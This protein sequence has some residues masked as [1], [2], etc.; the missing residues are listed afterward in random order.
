MSVLGDR[1]VV[2]E[3][4]SAA[5]SEADLVGVVFLPGAAPV[6]DL[7]AVLQGLEQAGL[8]QRLW[9]LTRGAVRVDGA[10]GPGDLEAAAAWGLGRVAAL[11]YP[12]WWGG[13]IDLPPA[14]AEAALD[15]LIWR[16][17]CAVLAGWDA[18]DQVAVRASGVYGRR[19][20]PAPDSGQPWVPAGTVLVTG[21]TGGLGGQVARWLADQ[22]VEHIVLTSR[23]GTQAPG[24]AQ[25][26]DELTAEGRVRVTVLGCDVADRDGLATA[27]SG[28]GRIDAVVHAAGVGE[29]TPIAETGPEAVDQVLA[30][31]VAGTMNLH[32][33]LVQD[34]ERPLDAFVMFSSGAGVWGGG[35]QGTYAAANAFLDAYA[36]RERVAGRAVTSVSWGLWAGPGMAGA[37]ESQAMQRR[38]VRPMDP[39]RALR[40]LAEAVGRGEACVTVTDM[41][42]PRF[43]VAFT[44]ARPSP[45][46]GQIPQVRAAAADTGSARDEDSALAARLRVLPE[47][48]RRQA[49]HEMVLAHAAAV[50][51]HGTADGLG[52]GQAFRELGFDSV[53]A[54][55][56]RNRLVEATGLSLPA[57]LVFDYPNAAVLTDFLLEELFG[58][59]AAMSA[60][61]VAAVLDEPVAIVGVGCRFPG[62]VDSPEALWEL[63][64]EGTD[65]IGAFPGNRGWDAAGLDDPQADYARVGG[66]VP[67]VTD[68]DAGFFGISPREA[69]A[70][71]PQQ[72]LVLQTAW[73]ALERAGIAPDALRGSDTG[74]YVG[75][76]GSEYGSV[77]ASGAHDTEGHSLT[78]NAVSVM[79]G[80]VSYNLG[81]EGPAVSV[82]TACSSSLV[83][84]H[85]AAQALRSGEC[86]M[87][88]AGGVTV[89]S[90]PG[91]F[92]EFSRQG[93]LA[94]DG[95]CKPFADAAD[96]TGWGEGAG[97]LVLERLSDA[98][99]HGHQILAMLRGSA[100]N[101]D[102][103][104]NGLTAPNGPSQQRVIRAALASARLS[105]ADVDVVEAHGTGTKLGDP[106]EAQALLATYGQ[107][108]P[109]DRPLWLGSVKSNIGHTQA[110][111]GVAGI[112]KIVLA[113]RHG[114]LPRTLHVD[115]PSSHV[116]W[117]AG[118]VRLL[119]EAVPWEP[120]GRPRRA[121]VSS[122]GISGTNAHLI[123]EEA[124][125]EPELVSAT[126]PDEVPGGLVPWL[127]SARS[128]DALRDQAVRLVRWS[129]DQ[130]ETDP[131]VVARA[132]A[133]SRSV[134]EHRAVVL[135]RDGQELM[136]GLR[137]LAERRP[138]AG[139][140]TG[141]PGSGRLAMVFSGQG[142]QRLGMGAELYASFPVFA[143]ALDEVCAELDRHLPRPI[144][145]VIN[146]EPD[147]LNETVF[148][149]A[150]LFAVQVAL[151]RL[152]T[153]WGVS[154]EWVAGHSIGELS[155]AHVAGVWSLADAASV[156][157][158]RGR[159]MQE[160]PAGGA[161]AALS[162][163]E[164]EALELIGECATVGLAAV[165]G[166]AS[167]VV[168]GDE[169]VVL[170]LAERWRKQG[171][172]ARRLQVS[173]AFHSLLMEPMLASFAQ[174]L[175]GVS[176]RE[177][178]FPVVSGTQDADVTD[179]AYWVRHVRETVRYHDT[180][181]TLR[182][183]GADLFL[184]AGPDGTLSAMAGVDSGVWVPALRGDRDEPETL[185]TALA[186][187]H[188]HSATVDWTALLGA[189]GSRPVPLPTYAF[190]R[191]R[192]WPAVT[193]R[194][195][196][197][198][199]LG[200]GE[201]GH[202]LLGAVVALAGGDAVV[203][204]GRLSLASY[205]WLADHA[206]LGSVLL[207]GTA[208]VDLAVHAG[209]RAGCPVVEEL[210]LQAPLLL[211]EQGGVQVQVRV[212][213]PDEQGRRAVGILSRV[214]DDD[215]WIRHAEGVLSSQDVPAPVWTGAWP[216]PDAQPLPVDGRYERLAEDGYGYG[217][218]FQGLRAAWQS[219]TEVIAE[220]ALPEQTEVDGFGI[221]PALLDAALHPIGLAALAQPSEGVSLPFAW[222][223]VRL[224]ATG[225]SV[226][227]V[228]LSRREDGGVGIAAFDP[229][230]QPVFS[231]DSLRLRPISAD[232]A[233]G[234]GESARSLFGVDWVPL[235]DPGT[236]TEV[237][238]AWHGQVD[239]DVPA[240]VVAHVPTGYGE[241]PEW[242][243]AVTS[244]VLGW[245]QT[246]LADSA[247]Q[248]SRL[249]LLTRGAL[250]G[251]DLAAAA[252][253]GLVRSAQSEHPG[254]FILLDLDTDLNLDAVLPTVLGSGEPELAV[255][256][257]ALSVRRLV[258]AAGGGQA[259]VA[260]ERLAEGTVVITGGTGGL[261]VLLA[262]HLVAT[263]EVGHL[264]LLSRRGI[265]AP[266]AAELAAELGAR[267][268]IRACDVS[269]RDAA[270]AVL[271][272]V[273]AQF[274][275]AGVVHAAGV[276]DDATVES[277]SP[278]RLAVVLRA[279]VDA[280]WHL[281]E[282]TQ[283][284]D[285]GLFVVY[286][287]AAATLGSAGQG[288][289]AAANAALD[290]LVQQRRSAGLAGHSLAW[291][292]WAQR[293]GMT[294]T[295][296]EA[297]L[298]RMSRAGLQALS[299]EEGLALFD[300]AVRLDRPLVVVAR[301][302]VAAMRASGVD[303]RLLRGLVGGSAR[304][305]AAS[306][307]AHGGELAGRLAAL[308]VEERHSAVLELVRTQ[309]ATV[310][311]HATVGGVDAD[312]A[313]RD[314]GFDSLT[315]V[316]LRNRLAS[317]TD[318]R[319]P[320]TLVFDY[321]TASVLAEFVLAEL[322]GTGTEAT[323][324]ALVAPVVEE[325]IAIVGMGCRFPGGVDSP[326]ALWELL[327]AGGEGVAEFPS[328]RGWDV[329]GLYD[330]EGLRAGTSYTKHGGFLLG[331]AEFDAGF[332]G[333][334]PREAVGMDPQQRI[335]LETAWEALERAGI[336]PDSLRGSATGVYLGLM[337][338][339]YAT[340]T[341]L[342]PA[343]SEGF[344]STGNSGSVASGRI[345]Y[346][347]GLEGPAV[348]VDTACSSS[349]VTVHLAAQALR[350][351]ECSL[352]L[353]GGVTVMATPGVF[354]EFSRQGGLA[355]DG[356]CKPF[357]DAA[358]GTSWGEG[359]GVLVLERLSDARRRGHQ[360]LAVLRGSAV[361]QD[362]ASNGLT[363]PNGPSQQRVIRAAL[364]SARLVASDVDVVEAHGTGTKL[365]DPIEAQALLAT[366]GQDRPEGRPLWL[367]SVKSNIGHTQAAA[368]VA[369]IMKMVLAMRH[370]VLPRTL[371]VDA[372]SSHVDWSAGA[373]ELLTEPVPWQADGRPRRAGV[374]SFGI[375]GTNA[376]VILEEPE[377]LPA[378]EPEE[379]TGGVVPWLLSAKSAEAL[380][381]QAVRLGEWAVGR[382]GVDVVAVG[383]AL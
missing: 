101:Q 250:D 67:E 24:A 138:G 185:V 35:G 285:L 57:T 52:S 309:A 132:L 308:P 214:D 34:A 122:F 313:F 319:L 358:D 359:A 302:D 271:E 210:T 37:Q 345:A 3:T 50:L 133:T 98:R 65:A 368:G 15:G 29:L 2:A 279:K 164:A 247:N 68:F 264:L 351:G 284:L 126:E 237:D 348:T 160:L 201:S 357:A 235:A 106:I 83:A 245:L 147:L 39:Q 304:R 175:E 307:S 45:L 55:E 16:R 113:M 12:T 287:S 123:F 155:A 94:T 197:V 305:A 297:D 325:P 225:A 363:A 377:Q 104:S 381:E 159:L 53:T 198:R 71:D 8:T 306:V 120:D 117:S 26:M 209:D 110:A 246:W 58:A 130:P 275:L 112:I 353:A 326:E 27:L 330:P 152:M 84:V 72:R 293:S 316:E 180:V 272:G 149:Q 253:T 327:A 292:L 13:L 14:D 78:G 352:A 380:R 211:P 366:Y 43:A 199:A 142:S 259:V 59:E 299:D 340:Q 350:S 342:N 220:V 66:F 238:W 234:A 146:G 187:V 315:A 294:G 283:G 21:G 61:V 103:A 336:V 227:R 18:E 75:V 230:G 242:V 82:D 378:V 1:A 298:A 77:L 206:V 228:R 111:A 47:G 23:R 270:A 49:V 170:E 355:A 382:P 346:T 256:A 80:R 168:S 376:H 195:G 356:R 233:S 369:G 161:M 222:T 96:G 267:V 176:W 60:P 223:G 184:E 260:P 371:H 172:K 203:L 266:G 343:E 252:V 74:V 257:G 354:T 323:D 288:S 373:V 148:T 286:S 63:L 44:S 124:E 40:A 269:D 204:T 190:Q 91:V 361:N 174:V 240:V 329:D 127:L 249:L 338:H 312:A 191:E 347:L 241:G 7:L 314:L 212:A 193:R 331:A 51:G 226:L 263:H 192:Y 244:T 136:D 311:G 334:S 255:R 277:L 162:A 158:A 216:P 89:M 156:V 261:G 139:V 88:L 268:S 76:G 171:G 229:A 265:D 11:E 337:Y 296:D 157:A 383:R 280:A 183:Q 131:G 128:A 22:D 318:L 105:S 278:E 335:V 239:G 31:K 221:H 186:G 145:D 370:G 328:D 189:Q 295:L 231:A 125:P 69:V 151:F 107:D 317:A 262:R 100:V 365:G 121:G 28:V 289:Y 254:R 213:E 166:P 215:E 97:I 205:P 281:H 4:V 273:P 236:T 17:C 62:G 282:L 217:P 179:P 200:L 46:L 165:N 5:L 118:A 364:A 135:G 64:T 102:G 321:P 73:E 92:A 291:G 301:L 167:T 6:K 140:L 32:R 173:H 374:S 332:F 341:A 79:S 196:D 177:P 93:G 372:P 322:L 10:D 154:P 41:D 367:G 95:R 108:R 251:S 99:R 86:S 25:L 150:G 339:D 362:G 36:L 218:V 333:I 300:A 194:A 274:P 141:S 48:R 87:A 81:L 90:T 276:L 219:G 344:G 109:Q 224:H 310:L 42:W 163:S 188:A 54:V 85:L 143:E 153:S 114:V 375:S 182:E 33:L 232:L 303:S 320:A 119:T 178:Q 116:D 290:A 30:A 20:V 70:M 208:F 258:R 56:L 169:D 248:D 379:A 144:R 129:A 38:G 181:L 19:L 115:A 360:V 137:T 207:P 349:L 243:H 202:G 324:V 9:M 134:F